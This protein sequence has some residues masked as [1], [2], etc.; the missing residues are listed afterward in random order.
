MTIFL[1]P[2][3]E[4]VTFRLRGLPASIEGKAVVT[5]QRRVS[6][7]VL[8]SWKANVTVVSVQLF[9]LYVSFGNHYAVVGWTWYDVIML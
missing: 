5:V 8:A 4:V 3:I 7:P 9:H 6:L 1:Y 2:A